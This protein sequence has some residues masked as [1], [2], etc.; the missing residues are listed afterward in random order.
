VNNPSPNRWNSSKK[1]VQVLCSLLCSLK[2]TPWTGRQYIGQMTNIVRLNTPVN[3]SSV[4]QAL[5]ISDE[6]QGRK[7]R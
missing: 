7:W 1:L 3:L 6:S 2:V 5:N 4:V